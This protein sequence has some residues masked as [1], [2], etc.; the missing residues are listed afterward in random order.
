MGVAELLASGLYVGGAG[1]GVSGAGARVQEELAPAAALLLSIGTPVKVWIIMPS[2]FFILSVLY[3]CFSSSLC[4]Y[5]SRLVERAGAGAEGGLSPCCCLGCNHKHSREGVYGGGAFFSLLR[6][7]FS[8]LPR[9]LTTCFPSEGLVDG[10]SPFCIL[11]FLDQPSSLSAVFL[12]PLQTFE[13]GRP[14]FSNAQTPPPCFTH[15]HTHTRTLAQEMESGSSTSSGPLETTSPNIAA[16]VC[17]C[18]GP[19]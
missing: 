2:L 4:S 10:V 1:A 16:G 18:L 12:P 14:C 8:L 15:I 19:D 6:V 9:S 5:V 3:A 13:I 17:E 7:F 11:S